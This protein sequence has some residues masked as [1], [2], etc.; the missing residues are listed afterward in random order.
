LFFS[1]APFKI[2]KEMNLDICYTEAIPFNKEKNMHFDLTNLTPTLNNQLPIDPDQLEQEYNKS[3]HQEDDEKMYEIA[4]QF[5]FLQNFSKANQIAEDLLQ[6]ARAGA[7]HALTLTELANRIWI[8]IA[9]L[10][11]SSGFHKKA[12]EIAE[13]VAPLWKNALLEDLET[14]EKASPAQRIF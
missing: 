9:L 11:A 4:H 13:K 5:L 6:F 1:H 8:K 7:Y 3:H 12:K 14:I 2:A 10:R